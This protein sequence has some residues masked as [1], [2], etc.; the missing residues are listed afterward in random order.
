[1]Q[2]KGLGLGLG[3]GLNFSLR[4]VLN[5]QCYCYWQLS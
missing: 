5:A 3:L 1:M 2:V 4:S